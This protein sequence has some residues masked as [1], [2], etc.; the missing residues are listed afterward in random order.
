MKGTGKG[1]RISKEDALKTLPRVDIDSISKDRKVDT[2]KM[3]LLRRKLSQRLVA[4]KNQTAM[5]T[6]F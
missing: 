6:T 2:S 5:L 1:G 4:V 3:S